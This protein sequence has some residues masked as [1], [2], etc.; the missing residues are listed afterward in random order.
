MIDE[1]LPRFALANSAVTETWVV[2]SPLDFARIEEGDGRMEKAL[3]EVLV[4]IALHRATSIHSE[5]GVLLNIVLIASRFFL[6]DQN[7]EKQY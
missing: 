4:E 2:V 3:V 6:Q 7:K 5:A 1:S